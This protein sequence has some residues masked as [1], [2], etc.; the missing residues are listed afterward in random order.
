MWLSALIEEPSF[1]HTGFVLGGHLDVGWGQQEHLVRNT[2]DASVQAE[3]ETSR[4]V[5]ETLRVTVD[6]FGEIHDHRGSL[7]EVLSDRAGLV[8]GPGMK[9][10][11]TSK[12]G[13]G[14]LPNWRSPL[15]YE[16]LLLIV[17]QL[18]DSGRLARG[19]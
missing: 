2:L 7:P 19:L 12:V 8:V 15:R 4:E 1:C 18:L 10:S 3:Y 5:D 17:G 13:Y 9:R 16:R 6:H 11:D 14:R